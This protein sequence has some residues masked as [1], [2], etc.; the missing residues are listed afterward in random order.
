MGSVLPR[1]GGGAEVKLRHQA[2]HC[3]QEF[4]MLACAG[5]FKVDIRV[6]RI[7]HPR[8]ENVLD[9]LQKNLLGF[10]VNVLSGNSSNN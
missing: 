1:S 6:H 3:G 10:C 9:F 5:L 8:L 7:M 2:L 4:L